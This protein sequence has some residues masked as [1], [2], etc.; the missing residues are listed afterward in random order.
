MVIEESIH[1]SATPD[2]VMACYRDVAA[3]PQWDPD[4]KEASIEG[5]FET[6]ATGRLRPTKG[7]A[8]R[9]RFVE[10]NGN[11]FTVECLAPLCT[12]RFE[13]IVQA[14]GERTRVTHRVSFNGPLSAFFGGL[15]GPRVRTGLPVTLSKLKQ[16]LENQH[17][18]TSS[19]DHGVA[20]RT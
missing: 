9:M 17:L 8:V 2:A 18:T 5:P 1:I 4:T 12:L 14:L 15:I 7:F 3:W 16:H 6:G 10:V 13:H 20:L 19:T 11:S